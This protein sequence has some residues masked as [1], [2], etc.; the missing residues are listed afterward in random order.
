V[1]YVDAAD[2]AQTNKN[3]LANL[4][5]VLAN[6]QRIASWRPARLALK[7][8]REML[9]DE[10]I[11]RLQTI[12]AQL[13]RATTRPVYLPSGAT[14]ALYSSRG[15]CHID[16]ARVRL[17]YAPAFDFGSGSKL[18]ADYVRWAY[19]QTVEEAGR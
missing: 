10:T 18:T 15:R 9:G 1:Q 12:A 17:D 7:R 4:K 13:G 5:L 11:D 8:L 16:K 14:L 3:P 6:P 19:P 2:L